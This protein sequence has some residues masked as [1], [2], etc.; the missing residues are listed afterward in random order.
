M[1]EAVAADNPGVCVTVLRGCA[2]MVSRFENS[3]TR[4]FRRLALVRIPGADR[5]MQFIDLGDLVETLELCLRKPVPGVLYVT[6][7][8]AAARS[9][10]G[11]VAELHPVAVPVPVLA[12]IAQ[13]TWTLRL[14]SA[15]PVCGLVMMRWPWV[16]RSE[17]LPRETGFR[18]RPT[19]RAAVMNSAL[20]ANGGP[21]IRGTCTDEADRLRRDSTRR[22]RGGP[23]RRLDLEHNRCRNA[24]ANGV[25]ENKITLEQEV[26][27]GYNICIHQFSLRVRTSQARGPS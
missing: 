14:K 24:Y 5:P 20:A 19:S 7:E 12:F 11:R 15:S 21:A 4:V 8:G 23:E 2:V 22:R 1:L 25:L 27:S 17:K 18:P 9:K 13:A 10:I 3:V 6:G 16:A 26:K